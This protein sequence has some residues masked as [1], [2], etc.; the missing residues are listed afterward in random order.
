MRKIYTL[1]VFFTFIFISYA[2]GPNTLWMRTYGGTDTDKAYA[3]STTND[4]GS[5]FVGQTN[6]RNGDVSGLHGT[7]S[8]SDYW[9]VKLNAAGDI[10]WQKCLG[11]TNKE[12]A[13]DVI[14]VYDGGYVITGL[15]T[16]NDGDVTLNHSTGYLYEDVWVVK[17]NGS[18]TL[19]WEKSFGCRE[20]EYSPFLSETIDGGIF[21]CTSLQNQTDYSGS[22]PFTYGVGSNTGSLD[23]WVI[24]LNSL[25]EMQWNNHYGG[26]NF[27]RSFSIKATPDGGCIVVGSSDS[28]HHDV[29]NSLTAD[30]VL[31]SDYWILKLSATGA[32]EWQNSYGGLS[33]DGAKSVAVTNDGGYIVAGLTSSNNTINVTNYHGNTDGWVIKLSSSGTLEWQKC[34]GGSDL[35]ILYGI[36]QTLDGGYLACGQTDSIDGDLAG[37]TTGA[38]AWLIKLDSIGNISW[39]RHYKQ[40]SYNNVFYDISQSTNGTLI[41]VGSG[42]N[43]NTSNE[44]VFAVK[45]DAESLSNSDFSKSDVILYPNAVDAILNIQYFGQ[46]NEKINVYDMLGK[47]VNSFYIKNNTVDMSSLQKGLYFVEI[48]NEFNQTT[49][50]KIIKI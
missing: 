2:Q 37:I 16:S 25:G 46:L 44:D 28:H 47:K 41:A 50:K 40:L 42:V 39:Q 13:S 8:D 21:V 17:I 6:S 15:T 38:K 29:T 30:G 23:Y 45:L 48:K 43:A 14:Q 9:V 32:I 24:K 19:L 18:G 3:V 35:D 26:E 36:I 10:Q 12:S 34:I 7:S 33:G 1:P 27:D 22:A 49:V 20:P 5:I 11:G 31:I 4:G